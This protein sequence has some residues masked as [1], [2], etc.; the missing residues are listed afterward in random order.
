MRFPADAGGDTTGVYSRVRFPMTLIDRDKEFAV[1][2]GNVGP[3][4]PLACYNRPRRSVGTPFSD[5][6]VECCH[7]GGPVRCINEIRV[8]A[9]NPPRHLVVVSDH[10]KAH[11]HSLHVN[12]AEISQGRMEQNVGNR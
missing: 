7:D 10:G 4:E 8:V 2:P 9:K 3:R 12:I 1:L 5:R 6:P 11:S